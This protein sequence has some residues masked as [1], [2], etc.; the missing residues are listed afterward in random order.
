MN[1]EL[2]YVAMRPVVFETL[3]R[4]KRPLTALEIAKKTGFNPGKV[5]Y[6]LYKLWREDITVIKGIPN[7][8]T[9]K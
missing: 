8:Y 5:A 3:R 1:Y 9:I 7:T 6:A 4:A 2:V